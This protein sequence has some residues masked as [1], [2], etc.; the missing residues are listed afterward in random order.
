M[1][2]KGPGP[3]PDYKNNGTEKFEFSAWQVSWQSQDPCWNEWN[4]DTLDRDIWI[5][6][7]ENIET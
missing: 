6:V 4:P 7:L 1:I 3:E 2:K 5:D